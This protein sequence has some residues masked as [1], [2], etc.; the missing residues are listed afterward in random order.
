M[1]GPEHCHIDFCK[2]LAQ[3]TNNKDVFLCIMRWHVR[4]GHLQ[5]LRSLDVDAA[6][7][8]A[9]G[10]QVEGGDAVDPRIAGMPQ[11]DA[12]NGAGHDDIP[13]ELGIRYPALQAIMSGRRNIQ[14]T[15]VCHDIIY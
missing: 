3:C 5:Y 7:A 8:E 6:D 4:A 15:L 2:R 1:Q 12:L 13:C 9:E 14:T 10:L 11:R